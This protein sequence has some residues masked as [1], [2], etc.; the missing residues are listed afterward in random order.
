MV[1]SRK[2][3]QKCR[4]GEKMNRKVYGDRKIHCK[5]T[6]EECTGKTYLSTRHWKQKRIETYAYYKGVCQRCGDSIPLELANVHHRTYKRQGNERQ[7]DLILYCN[8]CHT[9]IH[10]AKQAGHDLNRD[11]QTLISKLDRSQKEEALQ[12]LRRHFS[13]D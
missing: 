2:S 13:L 6:G 10:N 4:K 9:I 3:I 5:D 7:S 8:R 1:V 12:M 11:I